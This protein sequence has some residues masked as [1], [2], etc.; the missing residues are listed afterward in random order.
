MQLT[1]VRHG[2]AAIAINGNDD[3]RPLTERGHQ[4]AGQTAAGQQGGSEA[5]RRRTSTRPGRAL[6]ERR[7]AAGGTGRGGAQRV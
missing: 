6:P 3:K 5:G 4:Q 7:R 1:L 2:E